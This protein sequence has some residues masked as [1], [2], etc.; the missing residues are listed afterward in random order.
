MQKIV[1]FA[2]VQKSGITTSIVSNMKKFI[3]V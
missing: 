3:G 1:N 2:S